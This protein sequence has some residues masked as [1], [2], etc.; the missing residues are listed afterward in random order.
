MGMTIF[1]MGTL[2]LGLGAAVV[3]SWIAVRGLSVFNGP[4]PMMDPSWFQV[5]TVQAVLV[6]VVGLAI[7]RSWGRL[8][9]NAGLVG[10]VLAAWIGELVVVTLIASVVVGELTP[11]HGPYLWLVATGAL[12]QPLVAILGALIGK[13]SLRTGSVARSRQGSDT[14]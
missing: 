11:V 9:S 1:R 2:T 6:L 12:I 7:G 3:A 10:L 14:A 4:G 8:A 13:G 5:W